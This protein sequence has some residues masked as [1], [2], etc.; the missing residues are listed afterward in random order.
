MK[1]IICCVILLFIVLGCRQDN[2][3]A[4]KDKPDAQPSPKKTST[5]S[6][7]MKLVYIEPG[8]FLMG[9]E[10]GTSEEEPVCDVRISKGFWMGVTEVTQAQWKTMMEFVPWEDQTYARSG[11]N[12]AA[13]CVSWYRANQFCD[14][15]SKKTGKKIL[16]IPAVN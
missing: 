10:T 4:R 14:A 5:N 16:N 2:P 8:T 11:D 13:S 9:S 6:I 3:D 7:D 12:Y 1:K 15:L